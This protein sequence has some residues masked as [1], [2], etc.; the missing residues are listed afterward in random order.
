MSFSKSLFLRIGSAQPVR[1]ICSL[2][3]LQTFFFCSS[4]SMPT[5]CF[6][7]FTTCSSSVYQWLVFFIIYNSHKIWSLSYVIQH[8]YQSPHQKV[9]FPFLLNLAVFVV[10]IGIISNLFPSPSFSLRLLWY[11][12]LLSWKISFINLIEIRWC[13]YLR[14]IS[15][16]KHQSLNLN[17]PFK[18][19]PFT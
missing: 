13:H 14:T 8:L 12:Q 19:E 3:F 10:R 17:I 9:C 6:T 15:G 16:V 5:V 11:K 2:L 18:I 1:K 7:Q 4:I